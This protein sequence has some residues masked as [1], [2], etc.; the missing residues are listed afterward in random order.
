VEIWENLGIANE[1]LEACTIDRE[2]S[3]ALEAMLRLPDK[4]SPLMPELGLKELITIACW[5][6]WWERRKI[7]HD[8]KVQKP[9]KSAQAIAAIALNYWRALKKNARD[10]SLGWEKPK[11]DYVKLNVDAAFSPDS[12][13]GATGAVIRDEKGVF[14][15]GSSCGIEHIGDATMAE[16]RAVRDG[17]LLAGQLGCNKVEVE[18]DCMEVIETMMDNG[19]SAGV[20]A[21]IFEECAFLAR[22]FSKVSFSFCPRES[23]HV[24]H[25]LAASASG[26]QSVVW[27]DEPPDCIG[28]ELAN[29]VNLFT[30]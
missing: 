30:M 17:L 26:Y 12:C 16:A 2:G 10:R 24:A 18:S 7:A 6:I 25:R 5:Y 11:E 23:N 19:N 1:I 9:A 22:G 14:I 8:E 21:A 4:K 3:G 13:S 28:A 20:A 27:I 15:A 29:D